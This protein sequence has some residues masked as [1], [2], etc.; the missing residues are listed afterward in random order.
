MGST[1]APLLT[2]CENKANYRICIK[3]SF[4]GCE[5]EVLIKLPQRVIVMIKEIIYSNCLAQC[6]PHEKSQINVTHDSHHNMI[7]IVEGYGCLNR[8]TC[9]AVSGKHSRFWAD[10]SSDF[11][12][13][14]NSIMATDRSLAHLS[15]PVSSSVWW[16]W[17]PHKAVIH[18]YIDTDLFSLIL[19]TLWGYN[20]YLS[21][22][23]YTEIDLSIYR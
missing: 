16:K 11:R 23:G 9:S 3:L 5:M 7:I 18:L 15:E 13:L 6:L 1:L 2:S 19:R 14:L 10:L 17:L 8:Y 12:L 20:M 21:I 4:L 22:D